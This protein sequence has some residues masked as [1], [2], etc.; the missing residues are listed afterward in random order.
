MARKRYSPK[1]KFQVVG[2]ML[3]SSKAAHSSHK[4]LM[5]ME[6]G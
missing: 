2:K 5:H 3:R 1:L 6:A 4:M